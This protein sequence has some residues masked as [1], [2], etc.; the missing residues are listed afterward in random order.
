MGAH[1]VIH[2]GDARNNSHTGKDVKNKSLTKKALKGSV[3]GPRGLGPESSRTRR[4]APTD[5]A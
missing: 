3:R 5:E 1:A 4:R 2:G